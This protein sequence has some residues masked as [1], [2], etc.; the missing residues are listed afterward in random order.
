MRR[1]LAVALIAWALAPL[2]ARAVISFTDGYY[3]STFADCTLGD[4]TSNTLCDG[5]S[6]EDY[7]YECNGTVPSAILTAANRSTGGGGAG[8]RMFHLGGSQNAESSALRI[9]FP[10]G[11]TNVWIRW[12]HRFPNGQTMGSIKEHKFVYI[13]TNSAVAANVNMPYGD[14]N[15][16]LQMRNTM[17]GDEP[18]FNGGG[19]VTIFGSTTMDNS[20]HL[21]EMQFAL[22]NSGQNNGIFRF[23]VDG[24]LRAEKT[25]RDW[26]NGGAAS[27]TTWDFIDLPENHNVFNLAG[28]NGSDVD[29]LAVATASYAGFVQDG[30]GRNMIGAYADSPPPAVGGASLGAGGAAV[31]GVGG[32]AMVLE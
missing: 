24:V 31:L 12:Y 32:G 11:T 30:Q 4:V 13:F 6:A 16:Q 5:L 22:G 3:S 17:S 21:Y 29:D 8:F 2:P 28:C 26:Y 20:W 18:V 19:L 15:I 9:Q 27:P 7:T 10:A 23:W 1:L 25:D 14:D